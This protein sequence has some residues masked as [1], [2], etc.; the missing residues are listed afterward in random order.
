M[1]QRRLGKGST[2]LLGYNADEEQGYVCNGFRF[3][4]RG[5]D[6]WGLVIE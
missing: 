3:F 6:T 2:W 5:P 1:K 4:H